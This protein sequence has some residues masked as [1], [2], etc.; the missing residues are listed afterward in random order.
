MDAAQFAT[1]RADRLAEADNELRD[2]VRV[3]LEAWNGEGEFQPVD[4][5][6][7]V[8]VIWLEHFAAEAPRAHYERFLALFQEILTDSL[9]KTSASA[10]G[11]PADH[12][13]ERV[14]IFLSTLAVND[15]TMRGIGA[16]GGK[17]KRWV[18]MHDPS[19]RHGHQVADGQVRPVHEAFSVEG[20]DFDYPGQP[21]GPPE[22]WINCRCVVQ[23]AAAKGDLNVS[24]QTFT[25]DESITAAADEP[26]TG[27]GVFLLPQGSDPIVAASSEP[28]HLTTVWLG[29]MNDLDEDTLA[30]IRGELAAYAERVEGPIVVPVTERGTLG[31]DGADVVFLEP[32]DSLIALRN[33]LL[34]A[35][36]TIARVMDSVEQFPEWTPHVTLGYPETPAAGGYDGEAVTFD[37][38]GLWIGPDQEDFAMGGDMRD[39]SDGQAALLAAARSKLHSFDMAGIVAD[40]DELEDDDEMPLDELE[41]GEEL[42]TEVPVHGVATLEGKA[43]GDG[44]G[45]RPGA[46]SFGRLPAPLGY[47]FESSHGGDNSRV[48]IVGRIDEFWTVPA[49]G[50]PEGVFEVRW[51]GVIMPGKEYGARAIES[52]IDG[53]YDGLSVIVDDIEIDVSEMREE[54]RERLLLEQ[55]NDLAPV[56][57]ETPDS[58]P[59]KPSEEDL[60]ALVDMFVGDGT[61]E[62]TWFSTAR[63]RRFDM[64]PTGAYQ[65]GY[66]AL[67]AEFAD[68]MTPEQIEASATALADCDC[69]ASIQAS[70]S[71]RQYVNLADLSDGEREEYG[72][73]SPELQ[74]AFAV[75]R[76]L[77]VATAFAP[78]T[79]DGPG[80]ITHPIP[81]SRIRKY[82]VRGKGAAKIAW[83]TPG[84]FN[85]CRA[86]LAKYVQN[87]EWLAGLCANMHKEAIGVWPGQEGGKRNSLTASAAPAPLFSL[88]AALAP[89]EARF[90]MEPANILEAGGVVVDG[91][92]VYGYI[93]EWNQCHIGSPEGPGTCTY[94]P[95]SATSYGHYRT[96]NVMTTEGIFPV[97]SITM[98]TGHAGGRESAAAAVA[99]YDNTGVVIA[100][101]ACGENSRGIWFSGRIRPDADEM[102]VYKLGASGQVSGDW[103]LIGGNYELV[104]AL[105]VNVG[106]FPIPNPALTASADVGVVSIV[107]AGIAAHAPTTPMVEVADD[108]PSAMSAQDVAGI[109]IAAAEQVFRMQKRQDIIDRA[110]PARSSL[111]AHTLSRARAKLSTFTKE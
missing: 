64:V 89:V 104:A 31:D 91:E 48:A 12:E 57:A 29:D 79:K 28:A 84:D 10:G 39:K 110:A 88:T 80:W 99:H 71:G 102:D 4:L 109:A 83:G 13:V 76:G 44:R 27:V 37:R 94:A 93:A 97:G 38:M 59:K 74:D 103:R 30:S 8:E 47:E 11:S 43:T 95:R 106:G 52:I 45:F 70:A 82:W 26:H 53:S 77:V 14:T 69:S 19:V 108:A 56:P 61:M 3:A 21:V 65:E 54:M 86:N 78:G 49:P 1:I 18:S 20:V 85:R 32:T 60:D 105:A 51:R 98:S 100:D 41:D 75:E 92:H 6:E 35:S 87:P 40:V 63:V 9:A 62:V 111:A 55:R 68:E 66:A 96:G 50:E 15:G 7:A 33:G 73:L 22:F 23:P 46:I 72:A 5:A 90:F 101:V 36:P 67:G 58:G 17:F 25:L 34:E 16:R 24:K 42:I 2:L 81:T 107:A